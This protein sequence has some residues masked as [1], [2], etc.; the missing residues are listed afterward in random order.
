MGRQQ[1]RSK[2]A[3]DFTEYKRIVPDVENLRIANTPG[4]WAVTGAV[5]GYG[6]DRYIKYYKPRRRF[7]WV[8]LALWTGSCTLVGWYLDELSRKK[9]RKMWAFA[10]AYAEA[11]PEDFRERDTKIKDL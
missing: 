9:T 3:E 10:E 5:F 7:D 4:L 8:T 2:M 1:T 11:H 6:A